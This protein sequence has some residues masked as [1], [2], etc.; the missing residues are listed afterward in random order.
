MLHI[1]NKP[2]YYDSVSKSTL[3]NVIEYFQ[4]MTD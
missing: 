1:S 4:L 2:L 3:S